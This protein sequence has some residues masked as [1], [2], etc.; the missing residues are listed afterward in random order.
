[1]MH[2]QRRIVALVLIVLGSAINALGQTIAYKYDFDEPMSWSDDVVHWGLG[3]VQKWEI[4]GLEAKSR[5]LRIAGRDYGMEATYETRTLQFNHKPS[6]RAEVSFDV[7]AAELPP[8]CS[9]VVRHFDGYCSGEAFK[10]IA[11]E[12]FAPFPRPIF[13][14]NQTKLTAAWQ[15]VSINL[16]PLKRT[17]LTLAFSVRQIPRHQQGLPTSQPTP[18]VELLIKDLAVTTEPLDRLMDPGLDW[19]GHSATTRDL[20]ASTA[21]ADFDWCDF[22]D[23]EDVQAPDGKT[24]HYTLLQFRDT[25]GHR[26][27]TVKHNVRHETSH[28]GVGGCSSIALSRE[29]SGGF[30]AVSWGIR[31]TVAYSALGLAPDASARIRITMKMTN[32]ET[33][34]SRNSRVQVG[35]DPRG[36]VVTRKATW[37][38]EYTEEF[39]KEGWRLATLDFER[40]KDAVAFTVFF[41]H[42]DG[43]P[44]DPQFAMPF[45]EPQSM[46]S[47]LGSEAVAD[48]V[49]V[50][51]LP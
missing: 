40:P 2:R 4:A 7:R 39:T 9:L 19:H 1:M 21:G 32:I 27:G 49:L 48:W 47:Q 15:H 26:G 18:F 29:S 30:D 36:G 46:G 51:V 20:R 35:V 17:V 33:T 45:P 31:Q 50:E 44:G 14:S 42:R 28:Q 12:P 10:N 5:V 23:Q 3:G 41:R 25:S 43:R 24:I 37:S 34:L 6:A 22:A 8:G 11:D 16:G 38:D 13:D